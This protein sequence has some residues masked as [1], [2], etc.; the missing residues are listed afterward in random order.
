MEIFKDYIQV[1]GVIDEEEAR[2]LIDCGVRFIGFPLKLSSDEEDLSENMTANIIRNF[3]TAVCGILITYLRDAADISVLCKFVGTNIV[4]VHG[5]IDESQLTKLRK[6]SPNLLII[7]SLIVKDDNMVE[8]EGKMKI[9]GPYVDAF[10]T[11][12]YDPLTGAYGATGKTHN[13][14]ISRKL[15]EMSPKPIILAGGLTPNNVYGAII[16]VRPSGVD[17]HTGVEQKDGRKSRELV[18]VFISEAKR[19]FELIRLK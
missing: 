8:L 17:V 5:E 15:V 2:M 7:K 14:E 16:G 1:A 19:A 4:Q 11:D 18:N 6:I 3:P 9:F 10:L 13:W 12:T